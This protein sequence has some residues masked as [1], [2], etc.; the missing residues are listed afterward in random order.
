MAS[1]SPGDTTGF[2][3]AALL[4]DR[5]RACQWPLPGPWREGVLANLQRI[6]GM[7]AELDALPVEAGGK[8]SA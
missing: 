8:E 7:M 1:G 6:H 2:D 4:E 3:A 5:L